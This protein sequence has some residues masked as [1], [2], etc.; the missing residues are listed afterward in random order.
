MA[1]AASRGIWRRLFVLGPGTIAAAAV[2]GY[3]IMNGTLNKKAPADP[4]AGRVVFQSDG[5]GRL[6]RVGSPSY[7]AG[8][9]RLVK[10]EPQMLLANEA[11]LHLTSGQLH[12]IVAI[13]DFWQRQKA[14]LLRAIDLAVARAKPGGNASASQLTMALREYADLSR[15]F[16][17]RRE[18][19]WG[20]AWS[21]LNSKQQALAI[22]R[23]GI[24]P[25]E[26]HHD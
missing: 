22:R 12:Q 25:Q 10:P 5:H 24:P 9:Q 2:G 8:P 15:E 4:F 13:S 20:L 18:F 11:S 17:S 16:N 26:K 23:L 6:R 21:V 7:D 1:S 19:A 14:E 3:L